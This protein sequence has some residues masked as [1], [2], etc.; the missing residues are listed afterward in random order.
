M[1]NINLHVDDIDVLTG[2]ANILGIVT[3]DNANSGKYICSSRISKQS[4]PSCPN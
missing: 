4:N 3:S 1:F 2:I